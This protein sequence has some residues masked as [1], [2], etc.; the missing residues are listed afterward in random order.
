MEKEE[1]E[2]KEAL[3]QSSEVARHAGVKIQEI[4]RPAGAGIARKQRN[5][6]ELS[7]GESGNG[8]NIAQNRE[9]VYYTRRLKRSSRR[10][11]P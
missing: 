3:R 8:K 2:K 11:V 1:G 7:E 10:F 9:N 6:S 4:R 5:G